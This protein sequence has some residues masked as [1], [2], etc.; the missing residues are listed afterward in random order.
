MPTC[1]CLAGYTG[2]PLS[3]CRHECESDH[4]C[5]GQESCTNFRCTSAC[6][7]CGDGAHCVR[8]Q[9]H[10]AV[11]ECPKGY[12]G[13][14][15]GS[16][17][18]ECYGDRDCPAGRPACFYGICKNPCEG[19][20]GT[21]ADC[22]LRGLTPIC[23]CPRDMT[24]DPFVSCRPFT[25]GEYCCIDGCLSGTHKPSTHSHTTRQRT[26]ARQIRAAQTPSASPATTTHTRSVRCAPA[27]RATPAIRW[28]DACAAS[29]RAIASAVTIGR[30]STMRAWI[31]ASA[32][33]A[34][35]RCARQNAIWPCVSVR[36]AH[37]VMR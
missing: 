22:N 29:A 20:C 27:N 18:P 14:P 1:S 7:Q 30:A 2:S 23:S 13:S 25:K 15:F 24:G 6:S 3:G 31:R 32:S 9:N 8:V 26:C 34:P 28:R 11:C 35:V 36:M 21:G 10:R 33:A 5:G 4:E 17:K 16:C 19:S 12:I 37:R